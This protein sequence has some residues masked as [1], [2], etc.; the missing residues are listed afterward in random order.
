L[1]LR[2]GGR[3]GHLE[4]DGRAGLTSVKATIID[5]LNLLVHR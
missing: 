1:D 5:A 3:A 4:G 2:G